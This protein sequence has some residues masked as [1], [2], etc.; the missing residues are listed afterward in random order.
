MWL[1]LSD[2]HLET[3]ILSTNLDIRTFTGNLLSRY[4]MVGFSNFLCFKQIEF[5]RNCVGVFAFA[6]CAA[7]TRLVC[8]E[9]ATYACVPS[10]P[11]HGHWR[12]CDLLAVFRFSP[13]CLVQYLHSIKI[14]VCFCISEK[15]YQMARYHFIHSSDG[16]GCALFL[17]EY[18]IVSGYPS[19]VD[20]F[21]AQAV[22][23]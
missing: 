21:I 10:F 18:H 19:E 20:L 14:R 6:Y 8:W 1:R 2:G 22:L 15:N 4:G 9:I 13:N 12:R 7:T 11:C 23:Q 5:V 16:E 17:I 3:R